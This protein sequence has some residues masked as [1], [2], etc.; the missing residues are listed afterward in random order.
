[1]SHSK[2]ALSLVS[3]SATLALSLLTFTP[4][5][6]A[7][8]HLGH[9]RIQIYFTR[10]AEKQTQME[11]FEPGKFMEICGTEK[12]AEELNP[13]GELRAELLAKWFERM[14]ITK[15]LTHAFSSHKLRTLQTIQMIAA[16]AGL[17]GDD[18]KNADDGV[19]EL[20]V[21]NDSGAHAT[22]LDPEG[23]T[24][25]EAPT[26][27]ALQNLP[28][29]SVAL[30]AGHSGTLYDIM[31]GLGLTDACTKA[32]ANSCNQDRYPI[33]SK[34]KAKNYGDIWRIDLVN[35]TAK[36]RYRINLQPGNL[37]IE[38]LIR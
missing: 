33:D 22:E 1:M 35:G 9:S 7:N 15:R 11:E 37:K 4:S 16:D 17:S 2:S 26:I 20:P 14:R 3:V 24:P 27:E 34:I 25:S 36:F 21:F 10:H 30:V 23:T 38:E 5:V 28:S 8:E 32:T 12:C 29:G 6:K 31:Y 18:D 19:Q 13:A